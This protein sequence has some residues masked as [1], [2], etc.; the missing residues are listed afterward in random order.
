MN[1][2]RVAFV[3]VADSA[4][5]PSWSVGAAGRR[6]ARSCSTSSLAN[7]K[8]LLLL[9]ATLSETVTFH[10]ITNDAEDDWTPVAAST[11]RTPA[12][13]HE[14]FVDEDCKATVS[15]CRWIYESITVLSSLFMSWF[16]PLN[17][18]LFWNSTISTTLLLGSTTVENSLDDDEKYIVFMQSK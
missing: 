4:S 5:I 6:P 11:T 17:V 18:L 16:I 2:W 7:C 15:C 1:V 8:L 14:E 13:D 10:W 12:S 3:F 9:F